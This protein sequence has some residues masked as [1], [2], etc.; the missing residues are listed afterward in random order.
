M[1]RD[2]TLACGDSKNDILML[3]GQQRSVA[4]GNSQ[5]ELVAW[6][7]TQPQRDKRIIFADGQFAY[8]ILEGLCRHGLY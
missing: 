2:R 6:L 3:Q 4:V 7:M 1:P 8:G 5:P